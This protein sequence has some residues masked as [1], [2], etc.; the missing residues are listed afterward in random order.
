MAHLTQTRSYRAFTVTDYLEEKL[1]SNRS[2]ILSTIFE[3]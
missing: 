1:Y 2:K 3:N